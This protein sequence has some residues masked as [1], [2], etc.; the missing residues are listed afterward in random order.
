M[1]GGNQMDSENQRSRLPVIVA[2]VAAGFPLV[3]IQCLCHLSSPRVE[4]LLL[5]LVVVFGCVWTSRAGTT[6]KAWRRVIWL[7]VLS[8]IVR[9]TYLDW[10]HSD[11]FPR[12]LLSQQAQERQMQL[13]QM[14]AKALRAEK[15]GK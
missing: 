2:A 1:N 13:D 9:I 3:A 5:I 15:E 12:S 11:Y 10:L 7:L 8:C 14:H 6:R 4:L